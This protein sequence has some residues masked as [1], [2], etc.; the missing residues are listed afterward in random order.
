MGRVANLSIGR[1]QI[2][3][4][5][6]QAPNHLTLASQKSVEALREFTD[7]IGSTDVQLPTQVAATS[8]NLPQV[9]N[10]FAQR[11]D[12]TGRYEQTNNN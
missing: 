10:H 2:L 9:G 8:G 12:D 11:P 1:G 3:G 4:H 5:F 6:T 7:F